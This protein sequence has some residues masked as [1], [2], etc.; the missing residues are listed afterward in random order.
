MSV[1]EDDINPSVKS[2]ALNSELDIAGEAIY[3]GIRRF[4]TRR[5]ENE[6]DIFHFLYQTA[7]GIERLIKI[8]HG[9]QKIREPNFELKKSHDLLYLHSRSDGVILSKTESDM[10]SL[11]SRFYKESRY[12]NLADKN[13]RTLS[14]SELLMDFPIGG[15]G[16]AIGGIVNK[17]YDYIRS[18][19]E[20][21]G[22]FTYELS[23]DSNGSKVFYATRTEGSDLF[24]LFTSE[25]RAFTELIV[26]LLALHRKD[27]STTG[28]SLVNIEPLDD[29]LYT[30]ID[31]LG[32]IR[33]IGS[34][35]LPQDLVDTVNELYGDMTDADTI[36]REEELSI[37]DLNLAEGL[38]VEGEELDL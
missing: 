29:L 30:D 13:D 14:S 26:T 32:T 16:V 31:L 18:L 21:L 15:V 4:V 12:H 28:K 3:L 2:L 6:S 33:A 10:L 19:S 25:Q 36:R 27:L 8:S 9:L 38:L 17:Y 11:L 20:L 24:D 5:N 34:G 23:Y 37:F 35:R 7:I 22:V 1:I